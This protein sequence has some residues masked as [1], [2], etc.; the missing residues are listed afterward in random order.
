MFSKRHSFTPA[1]APFAKRTHGPS[2]FTASIEEAIKDANTEVEDVWRA[3]LLP[4]L[5]I[6][7]IFPV[8][9]YVC[10]LA[11]Q[12]NFVSRQF[13]LNQLVPVSLFNRKKE[14]CYAGID[15]VMRDVAKHQEYH[16]DFVVFKL[17]PF[18]P[19]T[20][21]TKGFYTW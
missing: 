6:S 8:K 2:W 13:G 10:M 5:L 20:Y 21:M 1:M 7:R 11:Y 12:P 9:N 14:I 15:Y 3:F 17:A 4:R 16:V 18:E 19:A